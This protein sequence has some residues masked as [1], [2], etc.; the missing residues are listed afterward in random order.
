MEGIKTIDPGALVSSGAAGC[1]VVCAAG[2]A[3]DDSASGQCSQKRM[4]LGAKPVASAASD[5][6]IGMSFTITPTLHWV[7]H[8]MLNW[9]AEDYSS[10][11]ENLSMVGVKQIKRFPLNT[12][13]G[14]HLGLLNGLEY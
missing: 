3:I 4:R 13:N 6:M 2:I 12:N 9:Q 1:F 5:A 14:V 11:E 8:Q 7:G 10:A